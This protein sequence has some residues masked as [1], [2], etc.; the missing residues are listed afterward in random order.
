[1]HTKEN[2]GVFVDG[3]FVV[4]QARTIRGADL[5]KNRAALR[6]DF[7]YAKAIADFNELTAGDNDFTAFG[8]CGEH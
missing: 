7:R 3:V 5:T 1:M 6:H 4:A 8:E 2:A